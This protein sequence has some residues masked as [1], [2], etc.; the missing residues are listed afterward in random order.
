MLPSCR[1]SSARS[2]SALRPHAGPDLSEDWEQRHK[3]FH[4]LLLDRF[5]SIW[6]LGFCST[7]MDQAVRYRSLSMNV[8]P[9]ILRRRGAPAEHEAL[10]NAAID[11]DADSA[12][13]LLSAHHLTT[14]EGLRGVIGKDAGGSPA[15]TFKPAPASK[16]AVEEVKGETAGPFAAPLNHL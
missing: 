4:I 8:H 10:L 11:R 14:L 16:A 9:N 2:V 15:Q 12:C 1:A 5:G 3:D 6:L 7:M 13:Q